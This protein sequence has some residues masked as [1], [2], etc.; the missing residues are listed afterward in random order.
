[1]AEMSSEIIADLLVR[2]EDK[3]LFI[4]EIQKYGYRFPVK[5]MD[6]YCAD[7]IMREYNRLHNKDKKKFTYRQALYIV[8]SLAVSISYRP[9]FLK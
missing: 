5:R 1:M 8:H 9:L 6:C 2:L 3:N 4:L 7:L